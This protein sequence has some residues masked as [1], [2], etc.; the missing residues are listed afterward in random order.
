MNNKHILNS[1]FNNIYVLYITQYELERIKH[2]IQDNNIKVQYFKGVNGR[3]T[4]A[5]KFAEY[6]ENHRENKSKTFLKTVGAYGHVHS[7]ISIIQDA[8]DKKYKKILLLEP[9]IYFI[10]NFQNKIKKYLTLDYKLLYFGGSQQNWNNITNQNVM[11][12]IG[13][14]NAQD[15]YGTFAI[16]LDF[17][18]FREYL[19]ILNKMENP[20]D[21]CLCQIHKKY[22]K[23]CIVTYP[24]LV[25][26]D[27]TKS[28]TVNRWRSQLELSTKFKWNGQDYQVYDKFPYEVH[29]DSIY[30]IVIEL[31]HYEPNKKCYFKI[32]DNDNNDMTPM[33]YIPDSNIVEHK[34][35]LCNDKQILS[36]EYSVYIYPALQRLPSEIIPAKTQ[37]Y[38]YLFG[39]YVDHIHFFEFF[40]N[41]THNRNLVRS[42][43]KQK[44]SRYLNCKNQILVGYYEAITNQLTYP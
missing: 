4:L 34:M 27:L 12:A 17:R 31:N 37:I 28:T 20:S 36:D 22:Q 32:T 2:K 9:D 5:D 6:Y 13:Y 41:V 23:Q 39:I 24:N 3:A 40:K 11:Q 25:S 35:K 18:I 30:K 19:D 8:I 10:N 21:V 38:I 33:I 16:A 26:C 29:T 44:V 43:F 7:M 15:T 42:H 14:Y 1:H